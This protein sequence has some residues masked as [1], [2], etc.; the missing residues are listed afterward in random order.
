VNAAVATFSALAAAA[1]FALAAAVQSRVLRSADG[2]GV[3]VG[4]DRPLAAP[5]VTEWRALA[6]AASSSAWLVGSGVAVVAFGLHALA[7]HEGSLASVQPL[8][9]T[10]VLF[11][12]PAR[13]VAGGPAVAGAE[14]GWAMLLVMG[15]AVFFVA[16]DPVTRVGLDVERWPAVVAAAAALVATG[17]CVGLAHTRRGG[18]A[19]ALLG[20]AAGIAFAGVAALVKASTDLLAGGVAALLASWQVYALLLVGSCGVAL[21]Q[22]AY[23]VGPL[24]AGVPAMNSVNPLVSVLIGV[25]VFDEHFRTGAVASTL[26]ALSLGAVTVATVMLSRLP[27]LSSNQESV[28]A[29]PCGVPP[30]P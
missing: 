26:E 16:A 21:S 25:A 22:L 9:V 18:G 10:T 24:S 20:A 4:A 19:A 1:L 8:L 11:A 28:D 13:R 15:L 14:I 12:L 7:L 29:R 6:R 30:V 2:P 5:S 17:F 27:R 23:R 3:P